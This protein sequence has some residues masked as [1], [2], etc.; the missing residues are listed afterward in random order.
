MHVGRLIELLVTPLAVTFPSLSQTVTI[1]EKVLAMP[2]AGDVLDNLVEQYGLDD[3]SASPS[4]DTVFEIEVAPMHPSTPHTPSTPT[5]TSD[6]AHGSSP[7]LPELPPQASPLSM[8]LSLST[9]VGESSATGTSP[10][11]VTP[12][13]AQTPP[14]SPLPSPKLDLPCPLGERAVTAIFPEAPHSP[15]MRMRA[16]SLTKIT[17]AGTVN[18]AFQ[19]RKLICNEIWETEKSFVKSLEVA[20]KAYY[21]PLMLGD[22]KVSQKQV[23]QL[24]GCMPGIF[25]ANTEFL[26]ALSQRME[27]YDNS[28]QVGDIF[29]TFFSSSLPK[30]YEAYVNSFNTQVTLYELLKKES[31]KFSKWV[32]QLALDESTSR[33]DIGSYLIQPVQRIPRY[34]LLIQNLTEVTSATHPDHDNVNKALEMVKTL[35]DKINEGKR[36]LESTMRIQEL[37]K[38]LLGAPAGFELAAPGRTLLREG[39]LQEIR[40]PSV[41]NGSK[42]DKK[43]VKKTKDCYLFLMSDVLLWADQAKSGNYHLTKIL[44]L[45]VLKVFEVGDQEI[46]VSGGVK[47]NCMLR[48]LWSLGQG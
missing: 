4:G 16:L 35:A 42:K 30:L 40:L 24:F 26:S 41:G 3:D 10:L 14:A 27:K 48:L 28:T 18:A 43:C 36:A 2:L 25:Q 12:M 20:L 15:K 23:V 45:D 38:L 19:K 21:K 17:T 33:L 6:V 7:S 22:L 11:P 32:K 34:M 8:K 5:S 44:P 31:S 9:Y 13:T 39:A 1:I 29:V 46:T 37:T 47:N